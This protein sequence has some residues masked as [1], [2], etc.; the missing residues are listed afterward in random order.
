[1]KKRNGIIIG[2]SALTLAVACAGCGSKS[3]VI[4]SSQTEG[5]TPEMTVL[6][7]A[8]EAM[9]SELTGEE[10]FSEQELT[11]AATVY[12]T[13]EAEGSV[14]GSLPSG[15]KVQAFGPVNSGAWYLVA[16]NGRVAYIPADALKP[17]GGSQAAYTPDTYT[18]YWGTETNWDGTAYWGAETEPTTAAPE[19][20]EPA[21]EDPSDPSETDPTDPEDPSGEEPSSEEDP[22]E[23]PPTEPEDPTD[24][25][26]PEEPEDPSGEENPEEPSEEQGE[27]NPEESSGED[28]AGS[29]SES[30]S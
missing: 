1:M 23:E 28:S 3:A 11:A 10:T 4:A 15:S 16:Y 29:D 8:G 17:A 27:E 2:I 5:I 18:Y 13:P 30:D 26:D 9:A 25:T 24:P 6:L 19:P 7:E 21:T 22:T 14:L 20:V 12:S